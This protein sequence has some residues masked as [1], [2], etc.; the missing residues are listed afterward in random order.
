M[1]WDPVCVDVQLLHC[2]DQFLHCSVTHRDSQRHHF[3]TFCYGLH[4]VEDR[5]YLW[6]ALAGLVGVYKAPILPSLES[7]GHLLRDSLKVGDK[8]SLC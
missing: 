5:K 8:S 4:T 1:G 6:G 7:L 3:L 2:M